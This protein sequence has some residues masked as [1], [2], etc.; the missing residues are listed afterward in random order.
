MQ[1]VL[2]SLVFL[3][4]CVNP[5]I[6]VAALLLAHC[7]FV[8]PGLYM[9]VAEIGRFWLADAAILGLAIN[10]L[11]RSTS[12][13]TRNERIRLALVGWFF[14]SGA[15]SLAFPQ[16]PGASGKS[17]AFTLIVRF[18][19]LWIVSLSIARASNRQRWLI[20]W[21]TVAC[22]VVVAVALSYTTI[23]ND[24]G[25]MVRYYMRPADKA[26]NELASEMDW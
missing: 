3:G 16:L 25:F 13:F 4:S 2:Y 11:A 1:A 26:A 9:P 12:G 5:V 15:F 18:G 19:M 14:L 8:W 10:V 24:V 6:G 17:F 7:T 23:S 20:L 22:G 21:L